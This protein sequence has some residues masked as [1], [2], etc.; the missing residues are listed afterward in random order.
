MSILVSLL[1]RNSQE[2]R[3]LISSYL[4][5]ENLS[6]QLHSCTESK[7]IL[8]SEDYQGS[9]H[10][11]SQGPWNT[12][13]LSFSSNTAISS[14]G[15]TGSGAGVLSKKQAMDLAIRLTSAEREILISALQEC[16]SKQTKAE[17]EGQLAA[18]RW[19]SKFG[20]PTKVLTLGDVDPTGSYCAV[21]D[22]WLLRKYV[23]TVP[24]PSRADLMKVLIANAIPFI[25]FG[26][27]DNA[28]M[29]IAGDSIE[30]T[31]GSI[32][33]I[34]T[35]GAA[36]IGNTISDIIGIGSAYY[37]ELLATKIGFQQPELTPI[38]MNLPTTRRHANAGRVLGVTIGC[39]LGMSPLLLTSNV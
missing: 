8:M 6:R 10:L 2:L 21:P 25:G 12:R 34:S 36:A 38:Q 17:Y 14:I 7:E 33:P 26:F 20:R 19:R 9:M 1:R 27:L 22:D 39:F 32:V 11:N 28:I 5:N 3:P 37:V 16:Q 15:S 29:I 13:M 31:L 24:N 35:M 4:N 23:E 30:A 18:F